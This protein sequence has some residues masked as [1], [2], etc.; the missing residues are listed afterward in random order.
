VKILLDANISWRL[1]KKFESIFDECMHVNFIGLPLPPND[2][3]I[4]DYAQ[5]N[6]FTVISNDSDFEKIVEIKGFPPKVIILKKGNQNRNQIE[7]IIFEN[8]IK[9]ID[10]LNNPELGILEIY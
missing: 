4:W 5:E 9:I 8:S 1:A 10:F 7:K 6:K 2:F 3:A